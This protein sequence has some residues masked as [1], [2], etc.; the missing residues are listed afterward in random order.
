MTKAERERLRTVADALWKSDLVA[1][2]NP[3]ILDGMSEEAIRA[4]YP[5]TWAY[6][7]I[8]RLLFDPDPGE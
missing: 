1:T 7:E 2:V 8:W 5:G 4:A 3:R 6:R